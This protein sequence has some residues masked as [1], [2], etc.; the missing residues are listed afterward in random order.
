M[1][2]Y[3]QS[4]LYL[5]LHHSRGPLMPIWR[6]HTC[7]IVAKLECLK[8]MVTTKEYTQSGNDHFLACIPSWWKNQPRLGCKPMGWTPFHYIHHHV[9]SWDIRC[10]WV[11]R[12]TSPISTLPLYELCGYN[13]EIRARVGIVSP[14]MGRGIDSWNRVWNW[15]AKLHRLA[16]RY[17]NT[18]P[19]G[20]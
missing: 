7:I 12:Y 9:Q 18:M 17:Y 6:L 3:K 14:A 4:T 13:K 16:G 1:N 2:T 19:T 20:F 8:R 5:F 10:S 15:E 11:G